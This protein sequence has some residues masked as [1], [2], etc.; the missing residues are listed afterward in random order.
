MP[1]QDTASGA[2]VPSISLLADWCD[3]PH[4]R[5]RKFPNGTPFLLRLHTGSVHVC[6]LCG[7]M[8]SD[9]SWKA[10][11]MTDGKYIRLENLQCAEFIVLKANKASGD[12]PAAPGAPVGNLNGGET[13]LWKNRLVKASRKLQTGDRPV[14]WDGFHGVIARGESS[15][16]DDNPYLPQERH[17][18]IEYRN[19]AKAAESLLRHLANEEHGDAPKNEQAP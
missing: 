11:R 9:Q 18:Y 8:D 5:L 12:A 19:G 13:D 15:S 10:R 2:Q 17:P 16:D 1:E 4:D 7:N 6:E 3:R 14:W